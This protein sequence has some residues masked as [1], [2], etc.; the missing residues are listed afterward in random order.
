MPEIKNLTEIAWTKL[1]SVL[2]DIKN[3]LKKISEEGRGEDYDGIIETY[4]LTAQT[5]ANTLW[6][7]LDKNLKRPKWL[8]IEVVNDSETTD[9]YVGVNEGSSC[10]LRVGAGETHKIQFGNKR[11]IEF[12]NY[13][14]TSGTASIR[15]VCAR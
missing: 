7:P 6:P 2:E 13:K 5:N 10:A 1:L 8:W 9:I 11:K 4:E 12:L 14:T 3:I 15:V